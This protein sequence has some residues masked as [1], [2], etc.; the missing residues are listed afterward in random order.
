MADEYAFALLVELEDAGVP[1]LKNKLV[2]YFQSRKSS[3]GDCEV[4]Y[5]QGERTAV[6]RFRREEDR[7]NV[8]E[9]QAHQISLDQGVLKLTVR[10]NTPEPSVTPQKTPSKEDNKEVDAAVTI[11]QLTTDKVQSAAEGQTEAGGS[12]D[13]AEDDELCC[14]SAVLGNIPKPIHLEFLEMLVENIIKN[15]DSPV[16]PKSFT[17]QVIPDISSAV[18]TFQSEKDNTNFLKKCP[19]HRTFQNKGFTVRPLEATKQIAIEDIQNV[20]EEI[21]TLSF[22]SKGLD[23]EKVVLDED[24]E[25]AF[26][27]FRSHKGVKKIT[28][29]KHKI[30]ENEYRVYPFYESLGVV[31]YGKDKPSL[32]LPAEISE[33]IDSA[34]WKYLTDNP[35]AAQTI[36]SDL[37]KHFCNVNLS[38]PVVCLSPVPS[39]LQCKDA[40]AT[41]KKWTRTVK[42]AFAQAMSQFKSLQ[43]S[44]ELQIFEECEMKIAQMNENVVAVPDR[45]R[46]VLSVVGLV[47]DVDRLH[48]QLSDLIANIEKRVQREKSSLTQNIHMSPSTFHI[49]SQDGFQERLQKQFPD[50]LVFYEKEEAM[51]KI[52]GTTNE[53]FAG[54]QAI[55]NITM[56]MKRQIL[57]LDG[58]LLDLLKGEQEEELTEAFLTSNGMNVAFEISARRVELL[59]VSEKDLEDASDYLAQLLKSDY[60]DVEDQKVLTMPEWQQLVS[61]LEK[62]NTKLCRTQ[63]CTKGTQVVVSG[64]KDNVD[65]VSKELND[66][67]LQNTEVEEPIVVKPQVILEYIKSLDTSWLLDLKNKVSVSYRPETICLTGS[68]ADVTECKDLF[69]DIITAVIFDTLKI[70]K[71]GAKKFFQEKKEYID[72][73][74]KQTGCLVQL[75][76]DT[77]GTQGNM[78][79]FPPPAYQLQTAD[80]VDIVVCKADMCSYPVHA[81]VNSSNQ[82]L[83]HNGGLAAALLKAAGPQLQD[84]CDRYVKR[85]G[86]LKPGDC[87]IT[88]AGGQLYCKNVIHT[89]AP[90]FDSGK[91]N[92]SVLLLKRA[93]KLC[94]ELAEV[95]S[96][97]TV[98]FPVISRGLGFPLD[99]CAV[100]IVKA[101]REHCDEKGDDSI[102]KMIHFVNNDDAAVQAMEAAVRHEFGNQGVSSTQ[103]TTPNKQP[104]GKNVASDPCLCHVQTKEGLGI[105]LKKGLI[106]TATTE[107]T[108]NVVFENLA[109]NRGAISNA[110]L[111]VAGP[112]LQQQILAK[113]PNG[114][115]GDIIVTDGCKLKSSHVFHAVTPQWDNDKGASEKI[116]KGI[117]R[118]CLAMAEN[119]GLSSISF[120]AM[121]TG[122]LGYPKDRVMTW[123][124]DECVA[125]SSNSPKHLKKVM[126]I[127]FPGDVKTIQAFSDEFVK[128]FPNASNTSASAG[129]AKSSGGPF[130]KV[131]SQSGLHETTMGSATIQ[132]VTGDIT[133]ETSD[134]IVNS[135]NDSFTLKSGVSKAIL[136]AAGPAVETECQSL[137]ALPHQNMIMT[138]PG[139]LKCNKILHLVGTT[140]PAGINTRMKEA[141]KM[142]ISNSY[143]S[144]SFPAIG[145]GQG[146][147]QSKS[148][149]DAML[150]AV[151][152]VLGKNSSSSLTT[153]RIVIFQPP[154]VND[155]LS[156]MQERVAG[157]N[158]PKNKGF[159]ENIGLKL[160]ALFTS[161]NTSKPQ[162]DDDFIIDPVEVDPACFHIC[163]NSQMEIDSAKKWVTDL[164]TRELHRIDIMDNAI[165]SF[166]DADHQRIQD[167]QFRMSVSIKTVGKNT[168]ASI[169]IEGLSKDVL[170]ASSEIHKMLTNVRVEEE[171]K[172]K[173]DLAS[174]V[175]D[176][177][178]KKQGHGF[179]S[180]DA[181]SNFK[182]EEALEKKLGSVNITFNGQDYTVTMPK[183]PAKNSRGGSMEIKRVDKLKDEE[184]P[185]HWDPMPANS[186]SHTVDIPAGTTE[187]NEVLQLFQ[188]T[189]P[190]TVIKI[191]RIQNPVLWKGLQVKKRHMESRKSIQNNE[192][193]LFH[194]TC[195]TTVPTINQY[196]FNR[197]YAGKNAACFGNGTYFAV[198]ASYSAQDTYSKPNQN[199]EKRM[200]LCRVLTG[201]F[202][203][204]KR[205]MIAPP[206]KAPG[207]IEMY[208]SVVDNVNTPS[209]FVIFHDTQACPE[210]LITFK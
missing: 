94:L 174:T 74:K 183:G 6:L 11:Q 201:E 160:R 17:L 170:D 181:M 87:T 50:L 51:L 172:R 191:E 70:S 97:D 127:V 19:Q 9:K 35:S 205:D 55:I 10:L 68:R 124:L 34:V 98:A 61:Q 176:W 190:R 52:T 29:Q 41:I 196:G 71:P 140:D 151:I 63:I 82:D 168:Q 7:R 161:D 148:V 53:L 157:D 46:G 150:D 83:K 37:A 202:A 173:V 135:S 92:K 117:F 14:T 121:G 132:I 137:A 75:V 26:I 4:D 102:L 16:N 104:A 32:K 30:K 165:L 164:V 210:Y 86:P 208:D 108:V 24:G 115:F 175:A 5:K 38:Q 114:N 18:V 8:L 54:N 99:L 105:T 138:Q 84:D 77:R 153:I 91:R 48:K 96:C 133:K 44:P 162:K 101:V 179:K 56:L 113:A 118:N 40:K 195:E 194:G 47:K 64:Y 182:L 43:F 81:V 120:P 42:S 59:G 60:I 186:A 143:S 200:Y 158:D 136:D 85:N 57:E 197:S 144:V 142:C 204:G 106:E 185:E 100:T 180:L 134:V 209:M 125:F 66:F 15:P 20:S 129:S 206:P 78:S 188:A 23:V 36:R 171:L 119:A 67:I 112:K 146:G 154:M 80:G 69:D 123:M 141:L 93:V 126:I 193:R 122:N 149:A 58:C 1:K 95:N 22:E 109:L 21:L 76:D 3:G 128:K 189:C 130:S 156:S 147:V 203:L 187:H 79:L 65:K 107:V 73:A 62:A 88:A 39:L 27:T 131:V 207:S 13:D 145:T 163:G 111:L 166:S 152:E 178:Y 198:N 110:I 72:L 192:R 90:S 103:K 25:S 31:L 159:W 49:L 167:I 177:Q 199:Q 28:E 12:Q 169:T 89:V 2:K 139:N 184:V 155:F 116:L 45:A 33:T